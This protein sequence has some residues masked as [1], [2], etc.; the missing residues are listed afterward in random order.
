MK[1][2]NAEI[3]NGIFRDCLFRGEEIKDGKPPENAVMVDGIVAKYGFHKDR[4]ESHKDECLKIVNTLSDKFFENGGGGWT[5]LNLPIDKDGNQWAEQPT[6]EMLVVM[7]IGLGIARYQL[8]RPVWSSLP[9]GMPYIVFKPRTIETK[10]P[11]GGD[12]V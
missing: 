11:K 12:H 4:L 8:P 6:A 9:G 1:K 10:Q 3:V 2:T 7:C 5:F